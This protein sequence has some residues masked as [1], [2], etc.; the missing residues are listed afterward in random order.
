[1]SAREW[2]CVYVTLSV[3]VCVC[4]LSDVT[5]EHAA[6]ELIGDAP[7]KYRQKRKGATFNLR[8][9]TLH[10]TPYTLH[11]TPYTVKPKVGRRDKN[12]NLNLKTL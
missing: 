4:V 9:Y 3:S 5:S 10:P 12:Y 11:P 8:P 6:A 2:V 1:M 7:T